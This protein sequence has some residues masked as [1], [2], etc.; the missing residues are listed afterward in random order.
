MSNDST[1]FQQPHGGQFQPPA[2]QPQQFQKPPMTPEES[3]KQMMEFSME[4]IA[5]SRQCQSESFWYRCL[6]LSL[7][8]STAVQV[9]GKFGV[10]KK[11]SFGKAFA[12]GMV[13][14]GLGKLSYVSACEDKFLRELP[15]SQVSQLIRKRRGLQPLEIDPSE[16]VHIHADRTT[17]FIVFENHQKKSHS[18]LQG[19]A[20][21]QEQAPDYSDYF[22]AS[23]T[24]T[25]ESDVQGDEQNT[26]SY[27]IL[28]E[29]HRMR[30]RMPLA[31][32]SSY[33]SALNVPFEQDQHS[34]SSPQQF[35][36]P[37]ISDENRQSKPL[38]KNKYGDEVY[39]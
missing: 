35:S 4:E 15:R 16:Q 29:Q 31:P 27:D 36:Q 7:A 13:G 25:S 39:E 37:P 17:H 32:K 11:Y 3:A 14:F 26:M 38:R 21:H 34:S 24:K 20:F 1:N 12:A 30:D 6:P 23:T 19:Q 22:A 10:L 33:P 28:R 9:A 2:G 18:F 5:I 8:M